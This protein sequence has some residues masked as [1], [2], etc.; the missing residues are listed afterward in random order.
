MHR[1]RYPPCLCAG[2]ADTDGRPAFALLDVVFALFAQTQRVNYPPC[3]SAGISGIDGRPAFA[4]SGVVFAL[5]AQTQPVHYLHCLCAGTVG[6]DGRPTF[7]LSGVVFALFAQAQRVHYPPCLC[8][9]IAGTD[10]RPAFVLLGLLAQ[11]AGQPLPSRIMLHSYGGSPDNVAQLVKGL[12]KGV[13]QRLYFSFS[14]AICAAPHR[15][16]DSA[17]EKLAARIKAVPDDRILI[18]SDQNTP[19]AIDSG[20]ANITQ[21]IAQAKGWSLEKAVEVANANFKAFYDGFLPEGW[22]AQE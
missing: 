19:L 6:T 18:E 8:A 7:A 12:P 2:L 20:L 1:V 9:G 5:F 3:L 13:G 14:Q 16:S 11:M 21:I 15:D 10:G 4:L 17:R 22:A